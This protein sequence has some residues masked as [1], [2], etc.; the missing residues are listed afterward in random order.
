MLDFNDRMRTGISKLISRCALIPIPIQ[1]VHTD[2]VQ[3]AW[4]ALSA[5]FFVLDCIFHKHPPSTYVRAWKGLLLLLLL[6]LD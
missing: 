5:C 4:L 6:L 1:G 3:H 2:L